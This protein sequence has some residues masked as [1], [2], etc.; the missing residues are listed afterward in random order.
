MVRTIVALND[1]TLAQS[2][3]QA[4]IHRGINVR[5]RCLT[6]AEVLRAVKDMGGGVVICSFKLRDMSAAELANRLDG[7]A[8]MLV[9]GKGSQLALCDHDDLFTMTVPV[10]T[11]EFIGAVHMLLQMDSM[12]AAHTIPKR[13]DDARA[14]I[15][16]A[17][18]WLIDNQHMS[19]PEAHHY[20]Q[21]HSM[22]AGIP[23]EEIARAFLDNNL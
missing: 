1:E 9:L 12:R 17:K 13:S 16:K 18:A 7:R 19:E 22:R 2:M 3:V 14:L 10:R 23:M 15:D 4:L 20:L 21:Q 11:S 5:Y 8:L 6:G